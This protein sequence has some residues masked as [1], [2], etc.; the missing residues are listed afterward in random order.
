MRTELVNCSTYI[1]AT[2]T[3]IIKP[4]LAA[5]TVSQSVL[6]ASIDAFPPRSNAN[7][8]FPQFLHNNS[9]PPYFKVAC[10]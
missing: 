1:H 8:R 5:G 6:H 9:L 4:A 10:S 3:Q 7:P 2:W